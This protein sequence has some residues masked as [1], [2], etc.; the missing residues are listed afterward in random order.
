MVG[1]PVEE[2]VTLNDVAN[3][4]LDKALGKK[5]QKGRGT[6]GEVIPGVATTRN[7]APLCGVSA[8]LPPGDEDEEAD[9]PD[10]RQ[11]ATPAQP[12]A[13]VATADVGDWIAEDT[14]DNSDEFCWEEDE[15]EADL[16]VVRIQDC[17][18]QPAASSASSGVPTVNTDALLRQVPSM[19]II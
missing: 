15:E 14:L 9:D 18:G 3:A 19:N 1:Q 16:D 8:V 6:S 10:Q 17:C 11:I 2:A 12:T 5:A 7:H 4:G 13:G